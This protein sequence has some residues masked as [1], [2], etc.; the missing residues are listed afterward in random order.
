MFIDNEFLKNSKGSIYFK[1]DIYLYVWSFIHRNIFKKYVIVNL[2]K[3]ISNKVHLNG[4][5]RSI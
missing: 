3:F 5:Y 4:H 2:L 1:D